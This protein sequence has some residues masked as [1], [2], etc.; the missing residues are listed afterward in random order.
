MLVQPRT[1]SH[2]PH[3]S[4]PIFGPILDDFLAWSRASGY[5]L[6]SLK[7]QLQHL[8]HLGRFFQR[9][10]VRSWRELTM[11]DFESARQRICPGKPNMGGTIRLVQR[12]LQ[13]DRRLAIARSQPLTRIEREV[14]RFAD[15]LRAVR[16][17]TDSTIENYQSCSSAFLKFIGY[18]QSAA[19]LS[20]LT[21]R[22]V[23]KFVKSQAESCARRTLSGVISRVR[24][25]LRFQHADG[26]IPCPLHAMIDTPRV[27]RL[28]QLPRTV[29]WPQVQALLRSIDRQQPHDLRDF[30]LLLLIAAYGLRCSEVVSLT[31]DDIDWRGRTLRVRQRKTKQDLVLPLTDQV[32]DALQRYLRR[33]RG[34]TER[35]DLFLRQRAPAG[36]LAATAVSTILRRRVRRSGLSL[37]S[38]GPHC[39]RH[40][41]AVRLLS[42]GTSMK[43]IG[44]TLGHRALTSTAVYLRLDV[45]N[46]REVALEVPR[47]GTAQKLL[48]PGWES[49]LPRLR[50]LTT[51]PPAPTHFRSAL[52]KSIERYVRLY[53]VLGRHYAH[54]ARILL[55]WD[56]FLYHHP[57]NGRLV[58]RDVLR[59]WAKRSSHLVSSEQRYRLQVVRKFLLFHARDHARTFIPDSAAFPKRSTAHPPRLVSEAEM[60]R[61]LA[62]A[63]RLRSLPSDPLRAETL[64][65][66]LMLLFCCGLRRGELMRLR[67]AHFDPQENLLRIEE[68]KFHKSRLLPLSGSVARKVREHLDQRRQMR[69]SVEDDSFLIM[70]RARPAATTS[71]RG[72]RL[73][74]HW[75][76]LCLTARVLDERGCPPRLH[77]LRHSFSVNALQ[78]W[79]AQGADVQSR[80]PHLAAYLGHVNAASTHYYL[81]LTPHLGEAASERFRHCFEPRMEKGAKE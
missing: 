37:R 76:H 5:A 41:F 19:R 55:D 70:R 1:H 24:G 13:E 6:N 69:L 4:S 23:D 10:R 62:T 42:Q 31:L 17:L 46:L 77:D 80:L 57:A 39:L 30:T 74:S 33:G 44:D 73:W 11:E 56:D 28:E 48:P 35:R 81:H 40:A 26:V 47:N 32:G 59:H 67:L 45:E 7:M 50:K 21:L 34:P 78:R 52:G 79:Y 3:R 53:Q 9:R 16:G 49:N 27:Y 63:A 36:P 29:P 51:K 22:S 38:I 12:F 15:H 72:Y 61:I 25:F 20:G 8:R 54:E 2:S 68:T 65:L 18:E 58:N 14:A 71:Y 66:A 43:T 60:G 75:R 64:R